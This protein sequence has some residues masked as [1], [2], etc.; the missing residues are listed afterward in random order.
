[1]LQPCAGRCHRGLH[2]PGLWCVRPPGGLSQRKPEEEGRW[3]KV[4]WGDNTQEEYSTTLEVVAKDR[5][6]LIM[7]ISTIL[8]S[9]KTRVTNM[10]AR[11][12]SDGFALI[13]IEVSV[14]DSTQLSTVRRRLEQV[15]GV[16][17]VTRPAGK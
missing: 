2:H 13:T 15:S 17:R 16:M 8:S 3:I 9:T 4:S 7:D 1:M 10:A 12:T 5:L 14:A 11:S 6:N